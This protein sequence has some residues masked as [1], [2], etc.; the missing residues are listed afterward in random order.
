[1]STILSSAMSDLIAALKVDQVIPDVI[2]ASYSFTPSVLF[3]IVWPAEHLEIVLGDKVAREKTLEEPEIKLQALLAPI[4]DVDDS[5]QGEAAQARNVKYT[6]VMTDP[7]APS[8]EDP[9]FG[10]WRHW[11]V[12]LSSFK[13]TRGSDVCVCNRSVGSNSRRLP[14]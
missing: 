14:I 13:Y 2:P 12:R 5:A 4:G 3:S 11:V 8:R 10:Q 7:D 9:K 1:M 6:L